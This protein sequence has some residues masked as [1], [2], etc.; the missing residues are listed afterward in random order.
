MH[1]SK[2][3]DDKNRWLIKKKKNSSSRFFLLMIR[4]YVLL[5]FNILGIDNPIFMFFFCFFFLL[6]GCNFY[7]SDV[8]Y[9]NLFYCHS[10]SLDISCMC[11]F[12]HVQL[13]PSVPAPSSPAIFF[14][15]YIFYSSPN[16]NKIFITVSEFISLPRLNK[17]LPIFYS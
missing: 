17:K 10:T 7:L 5:S 11:S 9:L 15:M 1:L 12:F 4:F 13:L 6:H 2:K 3:I 8:W 16:L 14:I